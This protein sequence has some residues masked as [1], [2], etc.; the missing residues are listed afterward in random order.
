[1]IAG[2]A[3]N[4]SGVQC[5]PILVV[6]TVDGEQRLHGSQRACCGWQAEKAES[7]KEKRTKAMQHRPGTRRQRR[8]IRLVRSHQ[9]ARFLDTAREAVP[10]DRD[11]DGI[12]WIA[13]FPAAHAWHRAARHNTALAAMSA[14]CTG[15]LPIPL[16]DEILRIKHML[17]RQGLRVAFGLVALVFLWSPSW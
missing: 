17:R 11:L 14:R 5:R 8:E 10:S 4:C 13:S 7:A 3:S 1:M 12:Q 2:G 6:T 9:A 15:G 16:A